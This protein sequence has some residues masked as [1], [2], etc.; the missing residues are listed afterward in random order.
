MLI[1]I[2]AFSK[3]DLIYNW[4]R[5]VSVLKKKILHPVHKYMYI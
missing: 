3:F 1:Q 2:H 4:K 5:N